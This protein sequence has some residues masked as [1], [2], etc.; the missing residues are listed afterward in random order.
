MKA[1]VTIR[2]TAEDRNELIN[3]FAGEVERFRPH[4]E[5]VIAEHGFIG[6]APQ[7]VTLRW[8]ITGGAWAETRLSDHSPFKA[9]S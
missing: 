3:T 6:L 4:V 2:L 1:L 5:K 7:D 8:L 9:T